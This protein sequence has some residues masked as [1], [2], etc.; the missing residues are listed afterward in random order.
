MYFQ[1]FFFFFASILF[2]YVGE[3][4]LILLSGRIIYTASQ[5]DGHKAEEALASWPGRS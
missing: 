3:A 1:V 2:F 5:D 4:A